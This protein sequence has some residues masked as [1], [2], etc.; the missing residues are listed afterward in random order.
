MVKEFELDPTSTIWIVLDLDRKVHVSAPRAP[1]AA[2]H[3]PGDTRMFHLRG[4]NYF[5]LEALQQYRIVPPLRLQ[6]FDRN[7]AAKHSLLRLEDLP[8][9]ASSKAFEENVFAED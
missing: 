1:G 3:T 5:A 6:N 7:D 2:A 8:H 4:G 9:T